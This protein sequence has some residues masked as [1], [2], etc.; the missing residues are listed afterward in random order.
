MLG[1]EE[2][3]ADLMFRGYRFLRLKDVGDERPFSSLRRAVEHEAF[4]SL[5][6][7]DVGVRTPRMRK[8][9]TVGLDSM[10]LAYDMIDGRSVDGVEPEDVT[11]ELLTGV[12]R[13]LAILR[14][15]RIAHRDLRL[16]N[17][18]VTP[19]G[20]AWLIDFGFAELAVDQRLLDTTS[21]RSWRR[22][23]SSP[24]PS[25]RSVSPSTCSGP[26]PSPMR[27]R[28]SNCRP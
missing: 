17:V 9:A 7:R 28:A 16:A 27:C 20:E 26:P 2:R 6:A 18:F 22:W 24:G 23:P 4:V 10:L 5:A 3:A 13:Q 25:A 1:E 15:N 8:V 12:F 11:D 21:P 14:Q 19:E